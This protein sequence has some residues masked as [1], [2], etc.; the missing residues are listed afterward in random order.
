[1]DYAEFLGKN[2]SKE[3]EA[4]RVVSAWADIFPSGEQRRYISASGTLAVTEM[5][6][7]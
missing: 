5:P 7:T 2:Y 6:H 4:K 3:I 1:M